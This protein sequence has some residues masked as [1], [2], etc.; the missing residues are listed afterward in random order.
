MGLFSGLEKFGLKTDNL[1]VYSTEEVKKEDP[2]KEPEKKVELKEEEY[3]FAKSYQC[4]ICDRGFKTLAVRAGKLRSY[5]KDD[6]LRPLY[7]GI[8][9]LKYDAIVC[10]NCGY[11]SLIRYFDKMMPTQAKR[12]RADVQSNFKGVDFSDDK[13]DY[14]EAVMRYK[15]VLLCDVVGGVKDSRKAYTCLKL[16]WIF[17][18]KLE[19]EGANMSPE[20]IEKLKSDELE[21]LQNAYDG[22]VSA[23]SK[24]SFPMSGMDEVTMS[25]LVAELAFRLGHYSDSLRLISNIVGKS[26]VSARVK[27]K[28]LDLKE[29]IREKVKENEQ[30]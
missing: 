8:D 10:P 15:M 5:G 9:P 28:C 4:P 29:R 19:A 12:L 7:K 26:S 27:D 16:A 14:D 21:C 2:Q 20:E 24:E 11:A 3:L 13:Y 6:D 18:G 22:Y 17:R 23:F 25:Y 1:E 30:A